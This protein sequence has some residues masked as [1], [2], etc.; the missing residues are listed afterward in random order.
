MVLILTAALVTASCG[1]GKRQS[2]EGLISRGDRIG[3]FSYTTA[4]AGAFTPLWDLVC[5]TTS[6]GI[7]SECTAEVGQ[8]VNLAPGVYTDPQG[9]SLEEKWTAQS[10]GLTVDQFPVDLQSFGFVEVEHPLVGTIRLWNVVVSA[11]KPG[12]LTFVDS[13]AFGNTVLNNLTTIH[14]VDP[15]D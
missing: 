8:K 13:G 6:D 4:E 15:G 9:E 10:Y 12:S 14:F 3:Q 5:T 7:T 11:D 2:V 1:L